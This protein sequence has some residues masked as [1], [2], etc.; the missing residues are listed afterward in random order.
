M[1]QS[2]SGYR[3]IVPV[4]SLVL[5]PLLMSVGDLVH[6]NER[7][8]T[9]DQAAIIIEHASRWYAAHLMLF[10]G[11]LIF[12][13]GLLALSSLM[14]ER[15]EW[16]GYAARRLFLVGAASFAAIFVAEM[17]VGRY[18]SNGANTTAA[19]DLLDTLQSGWMMAPLLAG[20][21]AFL[22]GLGLAAVSLFGD[23]YL[24]WPAVGFIAGFLLILGEIFSA[25]VLLSQIGN[26][27]ILVASIA[28]AWRLVRDARSPGREIHRGAGA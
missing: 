15:S 6:P 14:D 22:L 12:V 11:M 2:K 3:T 28:C 7:L 26:I 23:S 10:L 17:L 25:Q 1:T 9:A 27:V 21:V 13:P 18:V 8:D 16:A 24:R 20:G 5:G 19:T 4:G